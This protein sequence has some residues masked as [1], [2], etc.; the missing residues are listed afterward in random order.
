MNIYEARRYGVVVFFILTISVV[1]F[2]LYTSSNLINDL[3]RQERERMQIWAD[4]TKKIANITMSED[5]SYHS[6]VDIDFL[7]SIIEQNHSIPV[8]LTDDAGEILLHR[9]FDLPEPVDSLAPYIIS[10]ANNDFL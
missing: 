3:S 5:D 10:D 1:V 2:F 4:A 8:L 9:N 7:L 6:N